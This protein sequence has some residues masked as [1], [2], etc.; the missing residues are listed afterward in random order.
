[1]TRFCKKLFY[2]L[3]IIFAITS[4]SFSE[5]ITDRDFGFSLDIPEGFEIAD[6]TEDGMSYVFSHPNIPVTL[7]MK[8]T[9][10]KNAKSAAEVLNKNLKKLNASGETDSFKWNGTVCGISYFS[11]SLDDNY[12]GW[13]VSAPVKI[14]D[15]Y[16]ILL[17][18]APESKKGCEQ[19][20]ISTIN[21]LSINNEYLNT[22]GIITSYAF[23][24]E[25]S[26]SVLLKIGGKEIKTSLDK[27]DEEAAKFVIDLEYS[28]LNLYANHKMWK[29]AWQRYY[30]MI[31]R[32]NAG[33]LQQTAKNI[34]DS[35][36]PELKKSKPQDADI[37]YA[38][39]LLCWVQTFGYE[40]AQS[41]I[42]SDF[43]SLPASIKGKGSDCDS[44]SM[45][46]SVLLNYTG[47]DTA[48]LI[49]REYSHAVV[50]TDIPAPGQTFTMENG[51]EYLFGETTA[52][53][54]WGMLAQD[55]A[56]RTKWIPV[57]FD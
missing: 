45:L 34:Y 53:V 7:V 10:E 24:P 27:S 28:V 48:M 50:V 37:K 39:A 18:Y 40:R 55:Q 25:G 32:D 1:M 30:R 57:T 12:S 54:T 6:Y 13:A 23:P 21:S 4:Y 42:E 52:R 3:L 8:L 19:F 9:E 11:M 35:I 41:K 31:Y 5:Q 56:D 17:C 15:Y 16:V 14:Q 51:R 47:I 26:E 43:T 33:R 38:Q 44:R 22:P 49:S 46:V 29:E 36:Y 20:I 2:F